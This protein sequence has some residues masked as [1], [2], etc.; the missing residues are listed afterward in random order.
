[1]GNFWQD[2]R[3]RYKCVLLILKHRE[4]IKECLNFTRNQWYVL[5]DNGKN[6]YTMPQPVFYPSQFYYP[7][8][9]QSTCASSDTTL[10]DDGGMDEIS[11]E[12]SG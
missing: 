5:T 7:H 4:H 11:E 9:Q 2:Q 1:M 10:V 12:I 8:Y 3:K 6:V